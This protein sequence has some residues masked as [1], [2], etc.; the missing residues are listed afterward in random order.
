MLFIIIAYLSA[1]G[2]QLSER[3][4][5]DVGYVIITLILADIIINM[6][7]LIVGSIK[8]LKAFCKKVR[9]RCRQKTKRYRIRDGDSSDMDKS[10]ITRRKVDSK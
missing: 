7:V 6:V 5:L 8:D 9:E 4:I 3:A 1:E 10:D 2:N